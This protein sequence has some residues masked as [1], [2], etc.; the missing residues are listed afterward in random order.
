VLGAF[1]VAGV[2]HGSEGHVR[3]LD[4]TWSQPVDGG[5]T[6]ADAPVITLMDTT[7]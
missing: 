7:W 4:T 3:A 2:L 6:G 5:D 1:G